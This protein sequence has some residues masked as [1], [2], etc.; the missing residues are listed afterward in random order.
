MSQPND[1]S[2][3]NEAYGPVHTGPFLCQEISNAACWIEISRKCFIH[4]ALALKGLLGDEVAI[5]AV[6]KSNAYGHGLLPI[7]SLC[8]ECDE[9]AC[10][11][12]FL[13]SDALLMR[14]RGFNK[15]IIVLGGYDE[16][17]AEAIIHEIDCAVYDWGTLNTLLACA[18][19]LKKHVRLHIKV[20]TGLM[21][22][23]FEFEEMSAVIERIMQ[24]PWARL[25]GLFTHFAE[26]DAV[27]MQF[28]YE[29]LCR[30]KSAYSLISSFVPKIPYVHVANTSATLRFSDMRFSAVRCG[31]AL[32]GSCKKEQFISD[33]RS[34]VPLF[35]LRQ[36]V[37]LKT[38]V[39]AMRSVSSGVSVGYART[40]TA[41]RPMILAVV[42]VGYYDGYNRRL[43][44]NG[45][46]MI[47]GEIAPVVGLVGMNMT[48]LDV[49]NIQGVSI[50]DEV[51]VMGD[52]D[53][54]RLKDIAQKI[55]AIE[56]E[57][58]TALK[59]SIPRIIV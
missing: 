8:Q 22:L 42:A 10:C 33:V 35:S 47:R 3:L 40:F 16:N 54:I 9:I 46:M 57:C 20:N 26:S 31:G 39:I 23:G 1:I 52:S 25:M 13:L 11:A 6:I 41:S 44:N 19:K 2:V 12:V 56:Y 48:M 15:P 24:S 59:D 55:S 37:T 29:Q 49:T 51:V 17:V 45:C 27:D 36:V 28:T 58:L 21:R 30:F 4:N 32:Y 34:T 18:Q 43:S 53:G 7:S 50:G 38:R 5:I 14:V